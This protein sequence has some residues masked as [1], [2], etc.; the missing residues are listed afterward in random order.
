MRFEEKLMLE[1]LQLLFNFIRNLHR[2]LKFAIED[3]EISFLFKLKNLSIEFQHKNFHRKRKYIVLEL[4]FEPT[5]QHKLGIDMY[6]LDRFTT[7]PYLGLF[8]RQR[9]YIVAKKMCL[10]VLCLGSN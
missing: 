4:L 9:E 1:E 5:I 2:K 10:R 6:L 3:N 7:I 8:A